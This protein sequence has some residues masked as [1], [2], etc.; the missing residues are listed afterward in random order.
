MQVVP[1]GGRDAH[2][3]WILECEPDDA[4]AMSRFGGWWST[5][6]LSKHDCVQ[7]GGD[8][9]GR[10]EQRRPSEGELRELLRNARVFVT[11]RAESLAL[12]AECA[13]PTIYVP[14]TSEGF[15]RDTQASTEATASP[16]KA[17]ARTAH[18][19]HVGAPV[20][21]LAARFGPGLLRIVQSETAFRRD[22]AQSDLHRAL[23]ELAPDFFETERGESVKCR[24]RLAPHIDGRV[25]DLGHGG[26]K[27]VP[28]ALGVD[29]FKHDARD[30]IADVRDLWFLEDESF[31]TVYSSHCLEDLWHPM[32]ALAEWTR[33]LKVGGK[34]V[35][36]LPL[37][38]FYPNVGTE[39]ANPGHRDDY[40]PEDVVA[41]LEALG[42]C[43]I[44]VALRQEAE[45]SFEI[46]AT[47]RIRLA[48]LR[49]HENPREPELSVL[50]HGEFAEDPNAEARRICA[51]VE[52]VRANLGQAILAEILVLVRQRPDDDGLAALRDLE[53]RDPRIKL[54]EEL[55]PF[56]YSERWNLLARHAR[57]RALLTLPSGAIPL[58]DCIPQL[59]AKHYDGA[60]IVE[61][62]QV[63]A[64][65]RVHGLS[66]ARVAGLLIANEL[67]PFDELEATAFS[68][69]RFWPEWL[70]RVAT[71]RSEAYVAYSGAAMRPHRSQLSGAAYFDTQL[72]ATQANERV[73]F[74]ALRT[75]GDCILATA[76]LRALH[77]RM[78]D[79]SIDVVTETPYAWVFASQP[80]VERV[81][82]LPTLENELEEELALRAIIDRGAETRA[83]TRLVHCNP[84]A[85]NAPYHH[86]GTT[87]A[88]FYALQA[89]TPEATWS[90]PTLVV[91]RAASAKARTCL[92]Q[93]GLRGDYGVVHTRAGWPE[94]SIP[95][96]LVQAICE[97]FDALGLGIV[98]VGGPGEVAMHPR[99]VQLAGQVDAETSAALIAEAKIFVGPDSGPLHMA[100]SFGVPSLALYAGSAPRVAPP[101]AVGSQSIFST[102]A[103]A[104]PCGMTPCPDCNCSMSGVDE[105]RARASVR[106]VYQGQVLEA[107][108]VDG[109]S[110]QEL[111][112]TQHPFGAVRSTPS[113]G[114]RSEART[115][116]SVPRRKVETGVK[117][118]IVRVE[119]DAS[120]DDLATLAVDA[121]H[122]RPTHLERP[123]PRNG[124]RDALD[125][126]LRLVG[127]YARLDLYT[128]LAHSASSDRDAVTAVLWSKSLLEQTGALV[129]GR[130]GR[131]RPAFD[132]I[133]EALMHTCI[134]ACARGS[135]YDPRVDY[136]VALE[137]L[138][139]SYREA[140]GRAPQLRRQLHMLLAAGPDESAPA[141][142]GDYLLE[143]RELDGEDL[144]G[145]ERIQLIDALRR[146]GR[147]DLARHELAV[148]LERTSESD[149]EIR[150]ELSWRQAVHSLQ[151][152]SDELPIVELEY[153]ARHLEAPQMRAAANKL[154]SHVRKRIEP[155]AG[156]PIA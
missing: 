156:T 140:R 90:P 44:D 40:V 78:P 80:G 108:C 98:V 60:Q 116:P 75:L 84:R 37:R 52:A 129:E 109:L 72:T 151:D 11:T 18:G 12:A 155:P 45:D 99:A 94:K 111:R 10:T 20:D 73:L 50:V 117:A 17:S 67:W 49:E 95:P 6:W 8:P 79:A 33:V 128:S 102:T 136:V 24:D 39:G 48:T 22:L 2:K 31:D 127:R 81:L 86:C 133:F 70:D 150:A 69:E 113:L 149:A 16:S 27:I 130:D 85:D 32:Q 42:H 82:T 147:V 142:L 123:T 100:S 61:A 74:V 71:T 120:P 103:C 143:A 54:I 114:G 134:E 125:S 146:V 148:Q 51:S 68:T 53:A 4:A 91:E 97:E 7:I 88:S 152:A 35:L 1:S 47:K 13:V 57:G 112:L 62:T 43:S 104:L 30:W 139:A 93:V 15:V 92:E 65:A 83:Y 23:E 64:A 118:P 66:D 36:Y 131:A 9:V 76:S 29:C 21:E 145:R 138:F 77:A 122:L 25:L 101:L 3:V 144:D 87:L 154:L 106:R 124:A 119:L 107:S 26:C 19:T 135:C 58:A 38:D 46:V 41:M 126:I 110:G 14:D 141:W 28:N 132:H 105:A 56:A 5:V 63:D 59:L 153:A 115:W 137:S 121:L 89:R 34:L 96:R 55:R